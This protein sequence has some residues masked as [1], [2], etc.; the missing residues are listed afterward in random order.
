MISNSPAGIIELGNIYIKC[1]IF[2]INNE[3]SIEILSTST[4]LSKGIHNGVVVSLSEAANA[5]RSCIGEA[6]K[7]STVSL[8]KIAV[9]LEQPEFL[10]TKFSKH[11]KINGSKIQKDDIDFLLKEAK[12]QVI[13]NDEKHSIIHIFNHNYVVDGKT[14]LDEPIDVYADKLSH[15]MT[16]VTMPR[17]N[18]KNINQTFLECDIEVERYISSTFALAVKLLNEND[19]K[20]GSTLINIGFEKIS[21]GLFR[22]L[23]LVHSTTFPIGVNHL[24]KDIAKVCSLSLLES[25]N[26]I[27]EM[28]FSFKDNDHLFEN[29]KFLKKIYFKDSNF[30]KISK[31]L[32][33]N[34][35]KARLDEILEIT[36]K[37]IFGIGLN[38]FF[39]KNLFITGGGSK[40][41]NL[42]K[43][44]SNFFQYNVNKL[45]NTYDN[46]KESQN[47]GEL[48][49]CFGALKIIKEGWETEALPKP[50]NKHRGKTSFFA[51]IF[52]K[53][54]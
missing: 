7:K 51:K 31:S 41:S 29:N 32:I 20:F 53:G 6:E 24:K 12:K 1:L 17:N 54:A 27:N 14:F 48:D 52:G 33:L 13:L 34:V 11:R 23:A 26:I 45:E 19:L 30:R 5:I 43:Y 40:L 38:S 46:K 22:N 28:D 35:V 18:I 42:E 8:K 10:C 47:N 36:K 16:F 25:E 21:L 2:Q 44:F 15:E 39:K 37:Q 49:S 4:K 3:G 9:V 50:E